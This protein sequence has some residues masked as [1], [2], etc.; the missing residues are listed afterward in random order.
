MALPWSRSPEPTSRVIGEEGNVSN[1]G[2]AGEFHVFSSESCVTCT[3][4]HK[5]KDMYIHVLYMYTYTLCTQTT[6]HVR[7]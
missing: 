5:Y 3:Y 4:I 2:N 7:H 1:A 6:F